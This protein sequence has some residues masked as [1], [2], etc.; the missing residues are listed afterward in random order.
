[1]W[2][3]CLGWEDSCSGPTRSAL[4][5]RLGISPG[6]ILQRFPS[7]VFGC[8]WFLWKRS[9]HPVAHLPEPRRGNSARCQM[10]R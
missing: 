8:L 5:L 1:M 4:S 9:L 3:T 6:L 10:C 7:F 2:G